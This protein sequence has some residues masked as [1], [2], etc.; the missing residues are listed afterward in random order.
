MAINRAAGAA[1]EKR[2][3]QTL[4]QQG[5]QDLSPQITVRTQ[6]GTKT[7]IDILGRDPISGDILCIE[8]KPSDTAPLT[9]SQS[10]AFPEIERNGATV[11]GQGKPAFP[12]GTAIPPGRVQIM[13]P[14]R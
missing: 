3:I 14:S 9:P 7:R 4:K 13:R 8:C 1:F 12:G 5:V 2:S 10:I 11:V 6:S